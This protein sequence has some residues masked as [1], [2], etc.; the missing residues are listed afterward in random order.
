M[1]T[2]ARISKDIKSAGLDRITALRAPAIKAL[3][4]RRTADVTL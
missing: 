1:I 4:R 3:R 2:Q